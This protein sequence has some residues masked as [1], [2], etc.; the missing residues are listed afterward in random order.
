MRLKNQPIPIEI[1]KQQF[2]IPFLCPYCSKICLFCTD[3]EQ[4][5]KVALENL[6]EDSEIHICLQIKRKNYWKHPKLNYLING[7]NKELS[8]KNPL[9]I[10]ASLCKEKE[11]FPIYKKP[12]LGILIQLSKQTNH[13]VLL[14]LYT[15]QYNIIST[16]YKGDT[17]QLYFGMLLDLRTLRVNSQQFRLAQLEQVIIEHENFIPKKKIDIYQVHF[18]S[19]VAEQLE[20]V[21]DKTLH[22]IQTQGSIFNIYPSPIEQKDNKTLYGRVMNFMSQKS[23]LKIF[24]ETSFPKNIQVSIQQ[25]SIDSKIFELEYESLQ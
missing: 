11:E 22:K 19:E 13:K 25:F 15:D 10:D 3:L 1:R 23:I 7:L 20:T 17:T 24:Y 14:T 18:Q 8:I 2:S 5:N 6:K 12:H 9:S 4:A 21:I 16:E